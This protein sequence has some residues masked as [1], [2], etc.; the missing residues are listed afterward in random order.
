MQLVLTDVSL[1][2]AIFSRVVLMTTLA[3]TNMEPPWT[4]VLVLVI[5]TLAI[6][7]KTY[8][9]IARGAGDAPIWQLETIA[10]SFAL[11]IL[12]LALTFLHPFG[13]RFIIML[14]VRCHLRQGQKMILDLL[15]LAT[16]PT[17]V[18]RAFLWP[19]RVGHESLAQPSSTSPFLPISTVAMKL[20]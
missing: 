19:K 4:L 7:L 16:S 10:L 1:A 11:I 8:S 6:V 17:P 14:W 5:A 15:R 13:V 9:L 3:P 2:V 12:V 18:P 20:P